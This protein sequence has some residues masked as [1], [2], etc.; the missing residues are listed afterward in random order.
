MEDDEDWEG[1]LN[2]LASVS[3]DI[4]LED[5]EQ[6]AAMALRVRLLVQS[7]DWEKLYATYDER[8][9]GDYGVSVGNRFGEACLRDPQLR[10]QY[11]SILEEEDELTLAEIWRSML[12]ARPDF[13]PLLYKYAHFG[14]PRTASLERREAAFANAAS[15]SPEIADLLAPNIRALYNE[16]MAAREFP[17]AESLCRILLD[18]CANAQNRYEGEV[19]L[20]R[21]AFERRAGA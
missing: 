14:I 20:K 11:A 18:H 15:Q 4:N 17:I 5:Y 8:A 12:D 10:E 19:G 1:A 21:L 2:F 16:A 13:P 9:S 3:E 7:R 6:A